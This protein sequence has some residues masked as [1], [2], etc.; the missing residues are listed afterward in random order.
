MIVLSVQIGR[1]DD[2]LTALLR[3]VEL[4]DRAQPMRRTDPRLGSK[5]CGVVEEDIFRAIVN[6]DTVCY[7]MR[8]VR[9]GEVVYGLFALKTNERHFVGQMVPVGVDGRVEMCERAGFRRGRIEADFLCEDPAGRTRDA[10]RM[11]FAYRI[12]RGSPAP[13]R[14]FCVGLPAA[15][16][17]V[18]LRFDPKCCLL[19]TSD[20]AD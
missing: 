12:H 10:Q 16:L 9:L 3:E 2:I 13:I 20:A 8:R 15:T 1:D 18:D 11:H 17:P 6:D 7:E 14:Q 19:Y 4:F 5:A